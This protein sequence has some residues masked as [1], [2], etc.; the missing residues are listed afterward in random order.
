MYTK[1]QCQATLDNLLARIEE[2]GEYEAGS[3][4]AV[5]VYTLLEAAKVWAWRVTAYSS[6]I[7]SERAKRKM[8]RTFS[9]VAA[10][11]MCVRA[12]KG[13]RYNLDGTPKQWF[14]PNVLVGKSTHWGWSVERL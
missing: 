8:R 13:K 10:E 3:L 9:L 7:A 5:S 11:N 1:A 12:I 2:V 4:E 6:Y 14:V